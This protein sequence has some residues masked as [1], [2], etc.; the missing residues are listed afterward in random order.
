MH[1]KKHF[2][3]LATVLLLGG[4]MLWAQQ[5]PP[6]HSHMDMP[7]MDMSGHNMQEMNSSMSA[8]SSQHMDMGPHMKMT[9]LRP[10]QPG[11]QQ[12]ADQVVQELRR[13]LEK[14]KDYRAAEAD[15]FQEF[16]PNV[17]A[18]MR[19]F[20]NYRYALEAQFRFD[21]DH[22]TSL[23]YEKHGSSYKLI[24]AMYTAPRRYTEDDLDKRIP[25]S[26]AQ[27]HEHVNLCRPPQGQEREQ[28]SAHPR[29][30]LQGSIATREE[31]EAAGGT[32]YPI[33][34]SWMVHVYPFESTPAEI[35]S[36]ERQHAG[37][38]D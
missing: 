18:P 16:M 32:F 21:P 14:Y 6:D 23:L 17:P 20:T 30:G 3:I 31:C 26:V 12:R 7:G 13:V 35:W 11:D 29:F 28:L 25:L 38:R 33:I 9:E 24:G 27:W 2:A 4:T 22:P 36:V 1:S 8:M 37:H 5:A 10:A 15:G 19:H 34:F